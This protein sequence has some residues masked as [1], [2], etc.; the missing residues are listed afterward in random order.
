MSTPT[1]PTAYMPYIVELEPDNGQD[2]DLI[3]P[4][5]GG[6]QINTHIEVFFM[7][8]MQVIRIFA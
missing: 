4:S 6:V 3:T 8:V 5:D 1:I 7:R 2:I